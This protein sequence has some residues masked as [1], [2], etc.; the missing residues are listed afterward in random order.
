MAFVSW[1]KI[2]LRQY[3]FSLFK[4]RWISSKKV[5]EVAKRKALDREVYCVW[6]FRNNFEALKSEVLENNIWGVLL[7]E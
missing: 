4:K 5:K 2:V 3:I 1:R 6:I 7:T